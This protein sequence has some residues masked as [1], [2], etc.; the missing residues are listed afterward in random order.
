MKQFGSLGGHSLGGTVGKSLTVLDLLGKLD[1]DIGLS[2][3]ARAVDFDKATTPRSDGSDC[4]R[5]P[6][7]LL[8]AKQVMSAADKISKTFD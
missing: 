3:P 7:L 8:L 6:K 1:G 2:E 4:A 5:A